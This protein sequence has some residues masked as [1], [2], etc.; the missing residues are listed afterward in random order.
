MPTNSQR[1]KVISAIVALLLLLIV[2][3]TYYLST[4]DGDEA[5]DLGFVIEDEGQVLQASDM[6]VTA[7]HAIEDGRH[8]VAGEVE[9]P[10]PCHSIATDVT[11]QESSPEQV[12]IAFTATSADEACIQV[13][14]SRRFKVEF[15]AGNDA[16][17]GATW[18]GQRIN[19]NLIPA[20]PGEDLD[21]FDIFIKG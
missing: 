14:S 21:D 18:N 13:I 1:G 4:R 9:V 8:I 15:E 10:T 19:L 16:V 12:T 2:G 3:V 7:K 5:E 11:V 20:A 17:I 6:T